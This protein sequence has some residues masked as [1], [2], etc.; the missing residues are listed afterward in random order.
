MCE[1]CEEKQIKQPSITY[2]MTR[3]QQCKITI[4]TCC[5]AIAYFLL[6]DL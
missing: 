1:Q 3:P 5:I 6:I 4:A 2:R